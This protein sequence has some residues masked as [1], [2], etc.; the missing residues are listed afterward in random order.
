[1]SEEKKEEVVVEETL[2]DK[3]KKEKKKGL[4]SE[5]DKIKEEILRLEEENGK[6]LEQVGQ[7]KN[8]YARAY[9]DAENM[10]KRLMNEFEMKNKYR[11]QDFASEI[12]PVIDNCERALLI[13]AKDESDEN[14]RKGF[15]MV[16][17]QLMHALEK[18]G[19]S[20]IEALNQPFDPNWHQAMLSEH[21]EGVEPGMVVEVLQKGYKL[22][23][24]LLR[25]AMVKISE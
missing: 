23:D 11:I 25:A 2:N 5:V 16:K 1:M 21:I 8:E 10:K 13:E 7:L 3:K 4:K 24:R 15:E 19:V 20:E 22:K 18:E 14:Y 17:N 6:L 9:A 12:L